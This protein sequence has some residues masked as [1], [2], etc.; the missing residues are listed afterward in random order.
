MDVATGKSRWRSPVE[1]LS[2]PLTVAGGTVYLGGYSGRLD[3]LDA[4]TGRPRRSFHDRDEAILQQV[5]A[6]GMIYLRNR[7]D[8]WL[9]AI[10]AA[11]GNLQW[12]LRTSFLPR[13]LVVSEGM[14]YMITRGKVVAVTA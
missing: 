4:A 3:A 1:A 2:S 14:V 6:G 13:S 10:D 9:Y 7:S 8:Y 11:G 5:V 12:R